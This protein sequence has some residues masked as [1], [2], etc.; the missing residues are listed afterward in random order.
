VLSKDVTHALEQVEASLARRLSER[1]AKDR[2]N[3]GGDDKAPAQYSESVSR[4]YRS[5]AKKPEK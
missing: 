1:N 4:Y 2:V 5:L 3:S